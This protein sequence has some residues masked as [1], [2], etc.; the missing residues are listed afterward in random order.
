M[1][2]TDKHKPSIED[3]NLAVSS[4]YEVIIAE[5]KALLPQFP[6]EQLRTYVERIDDSTSTFFSPMVLISVG[7][8]IDE[9]IISFAKNPEIKSYV[10]LYLDTAITRCI[11]KHTG[12][13]ATEINIEDRLEEYTY[14]YSKFEDALKHTTT[15]DNYKKDIVHPMQEA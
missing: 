3:A 15:L 12:I 11:Y 14:Q 8:L 10:G 13:Q 1:Q 6:S 4:A 5:V 2:T 7:N 9:R